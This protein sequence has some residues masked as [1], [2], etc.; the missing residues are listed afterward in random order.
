MKCKA[1][2]SVPDFYACIFEEMMNSYTK[3]RPTI[4]SFTDYCFENNSKNHRTRVYF[5]DKLPVIQTVCTNTE[6]SVA[7]QIK[8]KKRNQPF[9]PTCS[10]LT[11]D[12]EIIVNE[13]NDSVNIKECQIVEEKS[14]TAG[15]FEYRILAKFEATTYE[16]A[17]YLR[18]RN[19]S[20]QYEIV[21]K[22]CDSYLAIKT[23]DYIKKFSSQDIRRVEPRFCR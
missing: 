5:Q 17:M 4:L 12:E 1:V 22:P 2:V 6:K 3:N 21:I 8:K 7:V 20:C 11:V 10:I 16:K 19:L 13:I 15:N 9:L 14:W 18:E 23:D